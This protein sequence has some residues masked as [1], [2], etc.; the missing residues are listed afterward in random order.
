[1]STK[2]DSAPSLPPSSTALSSTK[3]AAKSAYASAETGASSR[4]DDTVQITGGAMKMQSLEKS[5]SGSSSF[6]A[7][8]VAEV[9][10]QIADGS[11]RINPERIAS[12]MLDSEALLG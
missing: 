4:G 9:R 1:M 5:L 7:K 3:L 12:R 8:R 10:Q 6:D 2:I 11:Y